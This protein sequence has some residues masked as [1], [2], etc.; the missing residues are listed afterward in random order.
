MKAISIALVLTVAAHVGLAVADDTDPTFEPL[1]TNSIF[2]PVVIKTILE[3]QGITSLLALETKAISISEK[4]KSISDLIRSLKT[5]SPG[6]PEGP[7]ACGNYL[8]WEEFGRRQ[9]EDW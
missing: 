1:V 4:A 3:P 7:C 2:E 8:I 9:K 6:Q 5:P